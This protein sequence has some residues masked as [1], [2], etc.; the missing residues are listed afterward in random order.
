MEHS[1]GLPTGTYRRRHSLALCRSRRP[2]PAAP[3]DI[4]SSGPPSRAATG[5]VLILRYTEGT[6][7]ESRGISSE[8]S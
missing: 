7:A 5:T 2:G 3:K 8:R 4:N 1:N 6:F